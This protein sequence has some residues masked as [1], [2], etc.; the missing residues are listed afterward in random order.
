MYRNTKLFLAAAIA[1]NFLSRV[2]MAATS[3]TTFHDDLSNSGVNSTETTL[4]PS[5]INTTSFSKRFAT[6]VDG[7]I[8]AQPLYVP[9]VNVVSGPQAGVHN[10]AIVAT[11]HDSVYAIDAQSG[12]IVWQTSFLTTGLPNATAIT[13]MPSADTDSTDTAPEIGICGTPVIDPATNYLYVAAKTKQII[14]GNTGNPHYVYTLYQVDI[15][16]GNPTANANIVAST[17]IGNT[18]FATANN[19]Y[20]YNTAASPTAAQD[21]FVP[22]TGDGAIVVNGQSRVYFNAMRQMNRPGLRLYNG[23]IYIAFGSHGDNGP[24]HGW[25]LSYSESTL[26]LNGV[27]NTTPN[28]GLG[29]FWGGGAAPVVDSNGYIYLM[30][31][32]G[33]FDGY[34]NNGTTAGLNSLGFPV[35]GDYGDSI[36]KI[37]VDP[38][39]SVGNQSTNGWGLRIVDYFCP[40]NAANLDGND[41]DLGSGGVCLLP[42]SAGSSAHPNLLV[43]AGK[44]GNIYLVDTNAMGKFSA[45][46]DNVVQEQTII[47]ESFNTPC[48]FNGVL[49]YA[50]TTDNLK[51][52]TI[53]NAQMSTAPVKSPD[54]FAWPGATLS[55]SANG[56]TGGIIWGIEYNTQVLRA[57][58]A[59]NVGTELWNST[60]AANNTDALGVAQKFAAPTIA[61][62]Q[63]F[64][65]TST[66]LVVY[67][68][69]LPSSTAPAAPSNLTATAISS[70]Q[71][72]LAWTDNSNNES[73]F[74]IEGSTDGINFSVIGTVGTNVTT[75]AAETNI[76]AGGTYYFRVRAYNGVSNNV[77]STYTNIATVTTPTTTP[78][79]SFPGGFAGTAGTLV[80][81]GNAHGLLRHAAQHR[82]VHHDLHLPAV[83]RRRRWHDLYYPE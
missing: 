49:Y 16:N 80:Y 33:L 47:G 60:L 63:V 61:D 42:T 76:S 66:A 62:G 79:L 34:S 3:V 59:A 65:P 15:T 11:Q 27:L 48:F 55:V 74:S 40:S 46:T 38:T 13:T 26:T 36:L 75:Y 35:N 30:T 54:T 19:G 5:N 67:G 83:Q 21:I 20:T 1:L 8:Y 4:A 78:T 23:N 39:T 37:A 6:A 32:N 73:G 22:G 28:A 17:I 82:P 69:P 31:G 43:G 77:F 81:N 9:A 56:T 71:I 29:G 18:T 70:L 51:A 50:A 68:P 14:S 24:Y 52:F 41:T 72:N 12:N 45:T 2:A 64:A 53:A 58:S 57:Y 10:L 7:K 25:L 44:Q